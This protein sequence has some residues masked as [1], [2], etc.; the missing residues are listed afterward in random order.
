MHIGGIGKYSKEFEEAS[1]KYDNIHYYGS[2]NYDKVLELESE[3]DILFATYD[4]KIPN[5]RYSAP[6][7]FYEA[8][9]LKKPII[10]CRNTG[11][12][13]LVE[14]NKCGFVIE[15]SANEF[16]SIIENISK[17]KET[18]KELGEN[19]FNAYVNKYSWEIMQNRIKDLYEHIGDN[20]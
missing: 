6:N 14:E 16:Y 18:L 19:G 20:K 4:P 8:G 15:Y 9:A 13:K 12:D 3:C 10:V 2:L 17:D 11:V 5:H 7:K 1:K